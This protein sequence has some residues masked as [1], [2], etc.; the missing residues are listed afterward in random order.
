MLTS[1]TVSYI[2]WVA[3]ICCPSGDTNASSGGPNSPAP[4]TAGPDGNCQRIRPS[5][6]T[7]SSRWLSSSAMS[8]SAGNTPGSDPGAS[9]PGPW[10]GSSGNALAGVAAPGTGLVPDAR[11]VPGWATVV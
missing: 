11:G 7:S 5:G 8:T 4:G 3:T 2:S 1:E 6:S 10:A 9:A